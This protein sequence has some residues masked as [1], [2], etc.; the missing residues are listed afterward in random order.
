MTTMIAR[1][2]GATALS[3]AAIITSCAFFIRIS[4]RANSITSNLPDYWFFLSHPLIRAGKKVFFVAS[5]PFYWFF[6]FTFILDIFTV[7]LFLL[8][9]LCSYLAA[10]CGDRNGILHLTSTRNVPRT[11]W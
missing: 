4:N 1:S 10:L 9:V 2:K 5:V 3:H 7:Q 6:I 8:A 11:R